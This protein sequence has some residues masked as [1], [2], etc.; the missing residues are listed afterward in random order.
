MSTDPS[1]ASL[2]DGSNELPSEDR[3]ADLDERER[4]GV[5]EMHRAIAMR[6]LRDGSAVQAFQELVQ[7]CRAAPMSSR[8]ASSLVHVALHARTYGPALAVL[9]H[10]VDEAEGAERIAVMRHLARL[11]RKTGELPRAREALAQLLAER[12]Q[13][14]RAR[15]V[16][17]G[18]LE[19][20]ERWDELDASLERETR[21]ALTRNAYVAASRAALRRARMWDARLHDQARAALRYMQAAQHSEKAADHEGAFF[22]RLL[23]LSALHRSGAPGRFMEDAVAVTWR[24]AE[25]VGQVPRLRALVAELGLPAPK[26][27]RA[28]GPL[29]APL[30]APVAT[31]LAPPTGSSVGLELLAVAEAAEKAGKSAVA[32]AVLDVAVRE[33]DEPRALSQLE[34]LYARRAAWRPLAGLYRQQM[35]RAS[36]PADRARWA[37]KL[38]ELLESELDDAAGASAAWAEVVAAT[39]DPHAMSEHVRLLPRRRDSAGVRAALDAGVERANTK[40]ERA[41]ALVLRAEESIARRDV[42]AARADLDKALFLVPGHPQASADLAE[43]AAADGDTGPLLALE[44]TLARLPW[45]TKG[46]GDLFRRLARLAQ[47]HLDAARASG[48]WAEV[49][50]ELPGDEEALLQRVSLSRRSEDDVALARALEALV[51]EL[52][53]GPRCRAALVELVEVLDRSSRPGDALRVLRG[54]TE[55]DAGHPEPWRRLAERLLTVGGRDGEA[56]QALERAGAH[57]EDPRARAELWR[58]LATLYATRLHDGVRAAAWEARAEGLLEPLGATAGGGGALESEPATTAQGSNLAPLSEGRSEGPSELRPEPASEPSPA[59]PSPRGAI[60]AEQ[61]VVSPARPHDEVAPLRAGS[62]LS[63]ALVPVAPRPRPE[64]L[65]GAVPEAVSGLG[66]ELGATVGPGAASGMGGASGMEVA[67]H[68]LVVEDEAPVR[69]P[70]VPAPPPAAG[71]TAAPALPDASSPSGLRR[72]RPMASAPEPAPRDESAMDSER[73]GGDRAS[74]PVPVP[75]RPYAPR[76]SS[77]GRRSPMERVALFERAR[78]KPLE[79]VCYRL[80]AEFYDGTGDAVRAQLMRELGDALENVPRPAP[81][82]PSL[83][84]TEGDRLA[85]KHPALRGDAGELLGLVA[86]GLCALFPTP[87]REAGAPGPFSFEVGRGARAAAE[88]LSAAVRVVGLEAPSV[89]LSSTDGPPFSLVF[90]GGPRLLVGSVAVDH[91]IEAAE[92]RFFAGRALFSQSGEMLPLRHLRREQLVRGLAL[93]GEVARGRADGAEARV[94]LDAV[95]PQDWDRVRALLTALGPRLDA[96]QLVEAARHT[97]N[98]AGLIVCGAVSPALAALKAKKALPAEVVE[99]VRFAASERCLQLRSRDLVMGA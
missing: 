67:D 93:V 70:P 88:A 30:P 32:A 51:T 75:S 76:G 81:R 61:P 41:K 35:A 39:G 73:R 29:P 42:A 69:P 53:P 24:A 50:A 20:E 79:P 77:P 14:R 95:A 71:P 38:A 62:G 78:S 27:R 84:L 8:L 86:R 49:L 80:L 5:V 26:Q 36:S 47:E 55:R 56:A 43:L 72:A 98:R 9:S 13:D 97:A 40:E 58:R 28:S 19:H 7:A 10:G 3:R 87:A 54:A 2:N 48:A 25:R 82:A 92:L 34:T 45:H 1:G 6:M 60:G 37:E 11:A 57:T 23:W 64:E 96:G 12:P 4:L 33:A 15:A 16:L 44:A 74:A 21:D 46:R 18:L 59:L 66:V 65:P 17:N 22:L 63:A 99:L 90:V 94:L 83:I 68:E 85:L 91:L 31:T 89:H 52:P